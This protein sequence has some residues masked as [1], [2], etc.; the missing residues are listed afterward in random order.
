MWYVVQV[1]T[2]TEE[3]IITQCEKTIDHGILKRCFI[4]YYESM[5]KYK[6]EWHL[7]QKILFPGYVFMITTVSWPEKSD[8]PYKA[9]R[10]RTGN[11][12]AKTGGS[13]LPDRIWKR[14]TGC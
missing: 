10:D 5:K 13:R 14:K 6:G 9:D 8:R 2:G 1:R 4:P 11:H 12:S 7:E 3:E